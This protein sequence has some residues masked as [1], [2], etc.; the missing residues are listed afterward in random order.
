MLSVSRTL[1]RI[2]HPVI[3]LSATAAQIG[4]ARS[5]ED[6]EVPTPPLTPC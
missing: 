1:L 3:S 2:A 5:L 4:V 6:F